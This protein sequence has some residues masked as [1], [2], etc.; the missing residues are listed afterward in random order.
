MAKDTGE[1]LQ[2]YESVREMK[3]MVSRMFPAAFTMLSMLLFLVPTYLIVHAAKHPV[4]KYW[5]GDWYTFL[6]IVPIIITVV[7]IQHTR[8]G[9]DRYITNLALLFPSFL[10][11]LCGMLLLQSATIK[12]ELLFSS[13]CGI[14]E[15]KAFLQREW[16]TA[17]DFYDF[18][19]NNSAKQRNL[20]TADLSKMF[21]IQDCNDYRSSLRD[22][23]HSWGYLR[24]LEE[25][26]AC[27]GFCKPDKQLWSNGP[28]KDAC[29]LSVASVFEYVVRSNSVQVVAMSLMT[30]CLVAGLVSFIGP[31]MAAEGLGF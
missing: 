27:T 15:E 13:D 4:V 12:S 8:R 22:H 26:H 29:A 28:H 25:D 24:M 19:L 10:L 21:T 3:L 31:A 2:A 16:E 1:I 11:L 17:R 18:C 6:I 5:H 7:H 30:L 23:Q 14:M 9:P 20:T